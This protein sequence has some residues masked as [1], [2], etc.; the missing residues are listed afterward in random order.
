MRTDAIGQIRVCGNGRNDGR[1]ARLD[2]FSTQAQQFAMNARSHAECREFNDMLDN[3]VL[4]LD[5]HLDEGLKR[6]GIVLD[7]IQ[8]GPTSD[9]SDGAWSRCFN[10]IRHQR[11]F[12][13][14]SC[15][16]DE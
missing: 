12:A 9:G 7:Y 8:E 14:Q 4:A 1:T 16:V 13:A 5:Q 3:Q 10:R 11:K 6:L 2:I 15:S